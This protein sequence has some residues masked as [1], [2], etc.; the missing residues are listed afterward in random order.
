MFYILPVSSDHNRVD[1]CTCLHGLLARFPTC[2]SKL[3]SNTIHQRTQLRRNRLGR[4]YTFPGFRLGEI[5]YFPK[6]TRKISQY[7]CMRPGVTCLVWSIITT[8]ENRHTFWH[9]DVKYARYLLDH[10]DGLPLPGWIKHVRSQC[11]KTDSAHHGIC[12]WKQPKTGLYVI[13]WHACKMCVGGGGPLKVVVTL[14]W[15]CK[16]ARWRGFRRKTCEWQ[17]LWTFLHLWE[18]TTA[19]ALPCL[20]SC[21]FGESK[22]PDK[23]LS[24]KSKEI[25]IFIIFLAANLGSGINE[26][27]CLSCSTSIWT[28]F[29]CCPFLHHCIC[30]GT[31]VFMHSDLKESC[32]CTCCRPKVWMISESAP[33]SLVMGN[34]RIIRIRPVSRL[35]QRICS[36]NRSHEPWSL[37]DC[38]TLIALYG[39]LSIHASPLLPTQIL[40]LRRGWTAGWVWRWTLAGNTSLVSTCRCRGA[41]RNWWRRR[42]RRIKD[43]ALSMTR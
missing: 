17:D 37:Q 1:G 10:S 38:F 15:P 13:A 41:C 5:S 33:V 12:M 6:C 18:K 20:L 9:T 14:E 24:Y 21:A 26:E 2:V 31:C 42:R 27:F 22:H 3:T 11:G 19:F 7:S 32:P 34:T 16:G 4:Q 35:I 36:P 28:P 29:C 8:A 25:F 30:R 43:F 23:I 39:R 40:S